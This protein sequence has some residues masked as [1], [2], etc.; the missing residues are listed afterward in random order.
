MC[1]AAGHVPEDE[2]VAWVASLRNRND[3]P[4]LRRDDL[5][6]PILAD[7]AEAVVATVAERHSTFGRHNL[8]AEA[9]RMLHGVRFASP[10]DRVAVAEQ[11][12]E[13]ALARSVLLT[14]PALHHTP[15]RYLRPDGS[16]RL[17]PK[18]HL[19][20]TTATLLDAESRLL[21][22]AREVGGPR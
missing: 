15:E 22:V 9:H 6:E 16:S 11:I 19:L 21:E 10:D 20:Y 14:P 7:A 2:Q 13:L 12:T 8:L 1:R 17:R 3:L 18:N 5:A 4:L